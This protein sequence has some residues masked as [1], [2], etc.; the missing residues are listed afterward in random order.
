[1]FTTIDY[2]TLLLAYSINDKMIL[3]EIKSRRNDSPS[4]VLHDLLDYRAITVY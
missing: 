1:M 2:S 4:N 3:N